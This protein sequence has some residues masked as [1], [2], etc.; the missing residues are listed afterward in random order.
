MNRRMFTALLAVA[1]VFGVCALPINR[2]NAA[3]TTKPAEGGRLQKLK[4]AL[5]ALDLTE[6]QKEKV[7]KVVEETKTKLEALKSDAAGGTVDKTQARQVMKES[8]EKIVK[9]LTPAQ[10]TKFKEM[11]KPASTTQP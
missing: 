4:T 8:M 3:A 11:M 9:I 7:K 1:M 5:A 10:R 2:A 6:T